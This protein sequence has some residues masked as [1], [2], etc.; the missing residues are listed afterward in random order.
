MSVYPIGNYH[1]GVKNARHEKDKNVGERLGR[2]RAKC[3]LACCLWYPVS[4]I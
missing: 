1:F 2:M 3:G 4:V